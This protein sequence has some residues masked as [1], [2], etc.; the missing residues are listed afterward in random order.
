MKAKTNTNSGIVCSPTLDV[1]FGH[2][3]FF[4]NNQNFPSCDI[5]SADWASVTDV[6]QYFTADL[7][8]NK[9]PSTERGRKRIY[10]LSPLLAAP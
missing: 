8:K 5:I 7:K 3:M 6:L 9:Y 2:L 1:K 4:F 10:N